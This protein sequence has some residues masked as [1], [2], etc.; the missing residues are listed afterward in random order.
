MLV[1]GPC[2]VV[3]QRWSLPSFTFLPSSTPGLDWQVTLQAR[4]IGESRYMY[5][6]V[7]RRA[8]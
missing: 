6:Q 4:D 3:Y 1:T 8:Q 7:S 2:S 5:D